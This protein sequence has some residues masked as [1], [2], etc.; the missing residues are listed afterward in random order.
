M[1]SEPITLFSRKIE[2]NKIIEVLRRFSSDLE[3][4]GTA[5]NWRRVSISFSSGPEK[6]KL[7]LTHDPDYY[8]EPNWSKQLNG[9]R[10]YFSRFPDSPRKPAALM[11]T[12]TFRFALA[13]RFE[14]SYDAKGDPRLKVLF[15]VCKELDG[16]LF[17]PS[18]LRDSH[19]R[20]LLSSGGPQNETPNAVWPKVVAEVQATHENGLFTFEN[21]NEEIFEAEAVDNGSPSAQRVAKRGLAMTAVTARAILEQDLANPETPVLYADLLDWVSQLNI[22]DECEPSEWRVLTTP[23]GR[24]TPQDQANSTWRLEG[25]AVLAWGLGLFELPP[26]DT[27]IQLNP[28][29]SCFGLLNLEKSLELLA[30]PMLRSRN[31]LESMRKK[32]L[33][34]HWRIRDQSV[35]GKPVDFKKFQ[36]TCW[37]GPVDLSEVPL[38]GGDLALQGMSI[39]QAPDD[40][41][42]TVRSLSQERHRAANW[43]C[44][45]PALYSAASVAT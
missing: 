27:L 6:Q 38:V 40:L 17:T 30:N 15:A 25:L 35:N 11:L 9:M 34:L 12:T 32:L 5:D 14:P 18:S 23:L 37:F 29:W 41:L 8:S 43:L 31:E 16:V 26:H 4:D 42:A 45:G 22:R 13:T 3:I 24:L 44:E 2:P 19:G 7:S 1:A 39:Q 21:Q 33:A 20:I 28:L 36:Q 10:N